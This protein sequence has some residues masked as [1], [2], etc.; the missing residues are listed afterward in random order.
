M[1]KQKNTPT[2]EGSCA[3]CQSTLPRGRRTWCSPEHAKIGRRLI[4][5]G[6]HVET[7]KRRDCTR[8][9]LAEPGQRERYAC[10]DAHLNW[11]L[12][13]SR[14]AAAHREAR[15]EAGVKP[16]TTAQRL[17][18][19]ARWGGH[20][21]YCGSELLIRTDGWSPAGTPQKHRMEIDHAVAVSQ[22]GRHSRGNWIA[23]C[24]D[25]NRSKWNRSFSE[26]IAAGGPDGEPVAALILAD[27]AGSRLIWDTD[28]S[29]E[30]FLAHPPFTSEASASDV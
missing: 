24:L 27:V 21:A 10:S 1:A 7:C 13:E 29:G 3:L 5:R 22:G 20:C 30:I 15:A 11:L 16:W 4:R 18:T 25:C 6:F 9:V 2:S 19:H 14:R 28:D 12:R 17:D 8:L 23:V 26:W